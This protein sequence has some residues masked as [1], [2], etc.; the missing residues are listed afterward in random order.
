MGSSTAN[1]IT[2]QRSSLEPKPFLVKQR[3]NEVDTIICP[4]KNND[5]SDETK[6]NT[7]SLRKLPKDP[8]APKGTKSSFIYFSG[9]IRQGRYILT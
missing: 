4:K 8:D 3:V 6:T 2:P 7:N 5:H 1:L 9:A